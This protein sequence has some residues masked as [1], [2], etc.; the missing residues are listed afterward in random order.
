MLNLIR[1]AI[2]G[3][4]NI[5][6][7]M[8]DTLAG[9]IVQGNQSISM[10]AVAARDKERAEQFAKKYG[11]EKAY[12]SYEEMVSDPAVDLV[13]VATPH[14]HHYEHMKLYLSHGKHVLC[15]KAFTVN[16]SQAE[17]VIALARDKGLYI[18]EGIWTRYMP[19]RQMVD[20]MIADGAIGTP[21]ALSANFAFPLKHVERIRNPELAGGALLDLGV[22]AITFASMLFGDD[23][24]SINSVVQMMDTGV[25][26]QESITLTYADGKM[27]MLFASA[28]CTGDGHGVVYGTEGTLQIDTLN[29]PSKITITPK[30]NHEDVRTYTVPQQIT[31]FEYEVQAAIDAI[32]QGKVECKAMPH[33]ETIRIMQLMDTLRKQWGLVY[34]FE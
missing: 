21:H 20:R 32:E 6:R 12:G 22:Y 1:V 18:A 17:E 14:S 29:N 31:G 27:A 19:F 33:S 25:D 23:I 15:E 5:A 13:Y 26:E 28:I 2:L 7:K 30:Q 16:A 3:A 11:F 4:G 10:Y 9:M 8:A 24:A 34:P